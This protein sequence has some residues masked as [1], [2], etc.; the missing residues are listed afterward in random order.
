MLFFMEFSQ[1][2]ILEDQFKKI[3]NDEK[4]LI[5]ILAEEKSRILKKEQKNK[6][7]KR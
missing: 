2:S 4:L 5:H 7:K 3:D 6:K 1:A